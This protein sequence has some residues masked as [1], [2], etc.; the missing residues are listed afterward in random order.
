MNNIPYVECPCCKSSKV[1]KWGSYFRNICYIDQ[2]KIICSSIEIKRIRCK[3]C[4]HTHA[5]IPSFIVPYKIS[6]LDVILSALKNDNIT[7]SFN[8]D[9]ITSWKKQFY[10]YL[11]YLKTM[12]KTNDTLCILNKLLSNLFLYYF[13]F[14]K[15]VKKVLMLEKKCFINMAHF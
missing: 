9:T 10:K 8:L 12:L 2:G 11:P 6:L 5:L 4:E 7:I 14:Y 13:Q 1:I 3:D 15:Y